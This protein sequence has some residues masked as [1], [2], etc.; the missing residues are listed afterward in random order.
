MN[1]CI[2]DLVQSPYYSIYGHT[3][4]YNIIAVSERAK[5]QALNDFYKSGGCQDLIHRCRELSETDD[6]EDHGNSPLVNLAC[7][8]ADEY[9]CRLH[10]Q[11]TILDS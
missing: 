6:P 1:G 9:C 4:P 11:I 5:K 7:R 8:K 3:N 2:D 10:T